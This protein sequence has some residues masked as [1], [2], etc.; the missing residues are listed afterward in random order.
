[1]SIVKRMMEK[2]EYDDA[3]VGAL[4]GLIE[5]E[6]IE[7]PVSLGVAKK[8]ISDGSLDQLTPKQNAVFEDHLFPLITPT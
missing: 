6:K 8:I 1:M 7:H 3:V 5:R 4:S 2:A